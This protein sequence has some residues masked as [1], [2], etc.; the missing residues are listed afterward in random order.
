[1]LGVAGPRDRTQPIARWLVTQ[2]A[3]LH[4]PRD[5]Q[6]VVVAE[7]A[8]AADWEWVRWLPHCRP[9]GRQ[10]CRATLGLGTAQAAARVAELAALV[11]ARRGERAAASTAA[12]TDD[13]PVLLVVDGA[14]A[15]RA[16]PGLAALLAEGPEVGVYTVALEHDGRLL[17]E[18]CGATA[19]VTGEMGTRLDVHVVGRPELSGVL[20]DAVSPAYAEAVARALAPLRDDSR[21]RGGA[22]GLPA[23]VRWTEIT[24]LPLTGGQ[25]DAAGVLTRWASPGRTTSALLGRGPDGPFA[26]D[27]ARHGPHAL[28]AGTTGA[29]KSELLQTLIASLALG[30]RPDELNVLLVDFKGG[31]AF[32]PCARLPHTVGMVT[33]LDG[34]LVERALASLTAELRRREALLA[35]ARAKDLDDY[36]RTGGAALARLVIVVDEFATLA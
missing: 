22:Q 13:R 9:D 14:R 10:D 17:P 25:D 28:V 35:D 36:R 29:G 21:D 6:V 3:A 34:A 11:E 26:V 33:D 20:A 18:E 5:V 15:L 19:I 1:V 31:A 12:R 4:S 27:I 8:A 16:V 7:P 24:E 30:N 32:G 23:S 2:V